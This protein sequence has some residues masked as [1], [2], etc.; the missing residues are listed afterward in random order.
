[1][2]ANVISGGIYGVDAF[3]VEIEVNE[4]SGDFK[5]IIV[6]LPDAAVKESIDRV[7]TALINCGLGFPNGRVTI[8]LAPADVRKEGPSFDL[9]G[10]RAQG[11]TTSHDVL[12]AS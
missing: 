12:A 10:K 5:P 7:V 1:M 11:T 4:G 9:P 8:N 2:L 3:R 6:G